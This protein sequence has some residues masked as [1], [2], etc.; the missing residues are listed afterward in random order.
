MTSGFS[1]TVNVLTLHHAPV[2]RVC[3]GVDM[4]GHLMPLFAL[5]HLDDL[6]RVDRQ[7]L[8]WVYNHTEEPRVCLKQ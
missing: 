8:I 3:D 5:V 1:H 2:R 7:M 4:R 6:F